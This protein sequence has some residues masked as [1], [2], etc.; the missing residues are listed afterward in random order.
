MHGKQHNFLKIADRCFEQ[1]CWKNNID[2]EQR[3]FKASV[4]KYLADQKYMKSTAYC[5][6]VLS[7]FLTALTTNPKMLMSSCL[8]QE[9]SPYLLTPPTH[10]RCPLCYNCRIFYTTR[11]NISKLNNTASKSNGYQL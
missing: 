8:K 6:Y 1:N 9:G 10:K 4:R 11:K 3:D 7:A 2:K 5:I